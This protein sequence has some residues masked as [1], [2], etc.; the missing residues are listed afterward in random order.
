MR[1]AAARKKKEAKKAKGQEGMTSSVP[2]AVSKGLAKRKIDEEDDC[3]PKKVAISPRDARPK[4][5]PSKPGRGAS[6]GMMTL[7]GPVIKGP[8]C[9]LT[10]KD[11]AVK[12]VQSLIKPTDVD[13]CAEL[14]TE[15]LGASTLFD[16][17]RVNL[18]SWLVLYPFSSSSLFLN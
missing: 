15:E 13:P 6:K 12:E 16:L 1:V 14:G 4:K 5:S 11:Y 10:H 9:L 2:A 8:R 18:F 17:T 3:P 7:T